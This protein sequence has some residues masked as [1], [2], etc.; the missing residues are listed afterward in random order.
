MNDLEFL[1]GHIPDRQA[2]RLGL[3]AAGEVPRE[4]HTTGGHRR[5]EVQAGRRTE[6]LQDD[7]SE[8][9]L[10]SRRQGDLRDRPP[11]SGIFST[12]T[13]RRK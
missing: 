7:G 5:I 12:F 10:I 6:G 8:G 1:A 9:G 4:R 13:P 3:R 11:H 2:G